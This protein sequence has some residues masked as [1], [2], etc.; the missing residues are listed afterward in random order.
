[1]LD[2][3]CTAADVGEGMKKGEVYWVSNPVSEHSVSVR[4]QRESV[5]SGAGSE[6]SVMEMEV[7]VEEE[8][9]MQR[10][11]RLISG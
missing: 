1:M 10:M 5:V 3:T 4:I 2:V 7:R 8:G 11:L 9:D 6:N